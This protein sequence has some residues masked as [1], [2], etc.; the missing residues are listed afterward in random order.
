MA[1][2]KVLPWRDFLDE[3]SLRYLVGDGPLVEL[4]EYQ[5]LLVVCHFYLPLAEVFAD[6]I[7][8]VKQMVKESKD[9][10]RIELRIELTSDAVMWP[11]LV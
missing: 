11:L 5:L 9:E 3:L 2:H 10:M 8:K 4:L 6:L 7:L 1:L